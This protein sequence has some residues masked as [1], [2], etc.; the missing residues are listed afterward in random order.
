MKKKLIL[1]CSAMF[2]VLCIFFYVWKNKSIRIANVIDFATIAKV[3]I[4]KN[5]DC[6]ILVE[7]EDIKKFTD[8][9]DSMKLK[10][11]LQSEKDGF[12]LRLNSDN[13]A[14]IFL[15]NDALSKL[16]KSAE[17][18]ILLPGQKSATEQIEG[19][20]TLND[21]IVVFYP[22]DNL[23]LSEIKVGASVYIL[24]SPK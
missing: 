8:I 3:E 4:W 12:V 19:K 17:N 16:K 18:E 1:L 6:V 2:V 14:E 20:A 9:L 23:K 7:K 10:K 22:D 15:S 13:S 11:K 5:D 21:E 24:D